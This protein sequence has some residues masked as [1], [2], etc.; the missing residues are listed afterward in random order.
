MVEQPFRIQ[1]ALG[2]TITGDFRC[3]EDGTRKPVIVICH[4]F[5][6]H[7]NWGPFPYFGRRFAEEAFASVVFNFSHN[8]IGNNFRKLDEVEKFSR[9][10][11]R[12]ELD[13]LRAVIDAIEEGQVG[14]DNVDKNRVAVVGHSRGGGVAI[15]H[16]SLDTRVKAVAAWSTI[17]TFHR[18]THHQKELWERQRF[19]PVTI[20]SMQT[21]L[22]YGM[23]MLQDL[24]ANREQYDLIKAVQ[25]LGVPLLL[26]HGEADVT[27]KLA[28]AQ[29][30]YNASDKSKTEL[31]VVNHAGHMF[32]ARSGST[33]STP[34]IEHVT[35]VTVKWFHR[36]I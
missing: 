3:G 6:A 23:E 12:K 21:R 11:I 24:E 36:H 18:Y 34:E 32:G 10:T 13:D 25:R 30:L 31:V 22:R 15:L 1:N 19:L 27:V 29:T 35:D 2:D 9:N 17:A 28:E 5:T 26:V 33:R 20:R 16:A 4:G 14:G 7:K 8:G